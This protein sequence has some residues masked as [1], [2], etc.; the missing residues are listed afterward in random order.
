[1]LS[2]ITTEISNRDLD[3]W[4]WSSKER[5]GLELIDLKVICTQVLAQT[6]DPLPREII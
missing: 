3:I 2:D 1:M 4:I 5:P 6:V